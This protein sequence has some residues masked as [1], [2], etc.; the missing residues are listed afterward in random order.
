[1]PPRLQEFLIFSYFLRW[2]EFQYISYKSL[3]V[4]ES[5]MPFAV[6]TH[7]DSH[8]RLRLKVRN[9]RLHKTQSVR[10]KVHVL[11]ET[12]SNYGYSFANLGAFHLNRISF[13]IWYERKH[14]LR[15]TEVFK[16]Y[17]L[18]FRNPI[19]LQLRFIIIYIV[20]EVI[21]VMVWLLRSNT[22][23]PKKSRPDGLLVHNVI[24]VVWF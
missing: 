12:T 15:F 7:W 4:L 18:C 1:M 14:P 3:L 9:A 21:V 2:I 13:L 16:V 5:I 22:K 8:H 24:I 10:L 6:L 11:W 23:L 20:Q 19:F 17:L